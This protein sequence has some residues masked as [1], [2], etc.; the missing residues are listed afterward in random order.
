MHLSNRVV[1]WHIW[2]QCAGLGGSAAELGMAHI[3]PAGSFVTETLRPGVQPSWD[4]CTTLS[5]AL[6]RRLCL[7]ADCNTSDKIYT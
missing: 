6:C 5:A 2:L 1:V 7:F 4:L 3:L